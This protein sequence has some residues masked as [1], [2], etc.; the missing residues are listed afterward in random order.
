MPVSPWFLIR[1]S[2]SGTGKSYAVDNISAL[3]S[4]QWAPAVDV[5]QGREEMA[6]R[7]ETMRLAGYPLFSLDN[8]E[9]NATGAALC[10]SV[11]RPRISIRIMKTQEKAEVDNRATIYGTGNNVLVEGDMVRRTIVC[12]LIA[13]EER[14]ETH[15]FEGRPLN[16]IMQDRGR[17]LGMLYTILRAYRAAGCP[18]PINE[19]LGSFE[20]WS[21]WVAG[22]L[23]WLGLPN[24]AQCIASS[25]EEDPKRQA[26]RSL[27]AFFKSKAVPS[28]KVGIPFQ[29]RTLFT[30]AGG[31]RGYDGNIDLRE[32]LLSIA[33]DKAA[34][35]INRKRLDHWLRRNVKVI[36]D[37]M[38]LVKAHED[39]KD[40]NWYQVE[41]VKLL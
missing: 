38:R 36:V 26:L 1:A 11:E 17:Y 10:L 28:L 29:L 8:L 30:A 21:H 34:G 22:P 18:N 16:R 13:R 41:A 37:G 33:P 9:D 2:T 40:A 15:K 3:S 6:K 4:G 32:L 35:G 23:A 12:N 24:P 27:I 5:S 31:E 14:P 19:P 39:R 25:H 7:L 20:A